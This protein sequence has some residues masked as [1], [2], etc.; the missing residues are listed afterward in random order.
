MDGTQGKR[1]ELNQWVRD[2][3]SDC[4]SLTDCDSDCE[5][6]TQSVSRI[7][8]PWPWIMVPTFFSTVGTMKGVHTTC[9]FGVNRET[10]LKYREVT[11]INRLVGKVRLGYFTESSGT[12]YLRCIMGQTITNRS[13]LLLRCWDDC[14]GIVYS[15]HVPEIWNPAGRDCQTSLRNAIGPEEYM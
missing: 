3:D 12:Y 14:D 15:F 2:S 6:L 5:W 4:E 13:C 9:R 10:A 1:E 11:L 7:G 8:H